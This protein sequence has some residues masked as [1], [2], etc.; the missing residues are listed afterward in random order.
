VFEIK[1]NGG[2]KYMQFI[3][4]DIQQL[5]SS[6]LRVFKSIHV[7]D[8][9]YNPSLLKND[10]EEFCMHVTDIK[11]GEKEGL[12]RKIA[13]EKVFKSDVDVFF[14]G[15]F[16]MGNPEV[17]LSKKWYVWRLGEDHSHE[18]DYR[19]GILDK[20]YIGLIVPPIDVYEMANNGGKLSGFYPKHK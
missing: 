7:Y 12:W 19:D 18:V 10:E 17:K 3:A 2:K 9:G 5:N 14:K 1:V 16:D 15:T 20:A 8:L 6:V 4:D 13:N 11:R